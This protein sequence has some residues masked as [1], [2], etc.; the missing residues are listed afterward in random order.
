MLFCMYTNVFQVKEIIYVTRKTRALD[1]YAVAFSDLLVS[2][3]HGAD[4]RTA[5][6]TCH[7]NLNGNTAITGMLFG[8]VNTIFLSY[9][10]LEVIGIN[11]PIFF[12]EYLCLLLQ[13]WILDPRYNRAIKRGSHGSLLY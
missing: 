6:D 9:K 2:V 4:L 13:P 10:F 11:F 12:S 7:Q 8:L 1:R 3:L 5:V